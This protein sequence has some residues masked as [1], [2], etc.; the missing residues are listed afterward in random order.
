MSFPLD[1]AGYRLRIVNGIDGP[2]RI[3]VPRPSIK[4]RPQQFT[5]RRIMERR[6][7]GHLG[8]LELPAVLQVRRNSDGGEAVRADLVARACAI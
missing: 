2:L 7:A 8:D 6:H 3:A 1:I 5:Y 4:A